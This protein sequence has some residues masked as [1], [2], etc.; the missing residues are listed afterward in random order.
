M[1]SVAV[2]TDSVACLPQQV[3]DEYGIHII[4]VRVTAGGKT[5]QDG[6]EELPPEVVRRLQETPDIDTTP[7]PPEYYC[8]R[9]VELGR[10]SQD[11]VHV[12]A[13]SQFTSTISLARAGADMA[14]EAVPDLRIELL[15]SA[16]TTMAQ[17][18]IALAAARAAAASSGIEEVVAAAD[19]VKERVSSI[20]ALDTLQYLARTGRV[21]RLAAW[22]GSLLNV[23]PIVGLSRGSARPLALVRSRAQSTVRLIKLMDDGAGDT[24]ALHVAVMDV[25]RPQEAE[26]LSSVITERFRPVELYRV[27]FTP[28]M[29]AVAGSGL[30]GVAFY[31]TP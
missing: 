24:Q 4:P 25:D 15:D 12:V 22:A 23:R 21:N 16:T 5:Y 27:R 28:A 13:F 17:G 30:L 20:F 1:S 18:F 8:R 7:W 9:Y 26:E 11:I 3:I 2:V 14:Q 19:A 6:A 10:E 29:Q 31:S